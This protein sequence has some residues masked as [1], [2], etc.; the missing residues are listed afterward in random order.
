MR[1]TGKEGIEP[2]RLLKQTHGN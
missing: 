1:N 2:C